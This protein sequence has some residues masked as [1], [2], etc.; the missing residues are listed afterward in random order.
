LL[1]GVFYWFLAKIIIRCEVL[2]CTPFDFRSLIL[3]FELVGNVAS[4]GL[5][6][7]ACNLS[8]QR[9]LS[10][11]ASFFF[12]QRD[13][14]CTGDGNPEQKATKFFSISSCLGLAVLPF[15]PARG[16]LCQRGGFRQYLSPTKTKKVK[17][18][19]LFSPFKTFPAIVFRGV[20][21]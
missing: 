3:L 19:N 2:K 1:I 9:R 15:L 10:R 5:Q 12:V 7:F 13:F 4:V 11:S 14:T 20:G 6:R 18:I 8:V 21:N 17:A 16:T